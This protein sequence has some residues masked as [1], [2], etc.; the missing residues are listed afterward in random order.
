MLENEEII[1]RIMYVKPEG[2]M[3]KGRPRMGCMDCVEKD[4]RDLGLVN[5]KKRQKSWNFF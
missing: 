2:K 1:K 4:L 5:W 3:K